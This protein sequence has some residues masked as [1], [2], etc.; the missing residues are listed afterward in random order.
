[1]GGHTAHMGEMRNVFEYSKN[2]EG[3]QHLND[4]GINGRSISNT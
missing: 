2:L 1:M 3:R 4:Q